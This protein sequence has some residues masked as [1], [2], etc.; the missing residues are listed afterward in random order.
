VSD[1]G[2]Q[3]RINRIFRGPNRK[4]LVVA[5]DHALILGPIPGTIDPSSQ[6]RRFADGGADAVLLNFGVLQRGID[7]L[8]VENAPALILRLDW[9][10]LWTAGN[11]NGKLISQLIATPEQALQHGADAVLT[12]LFVGT[13]DSEFESREIARNAQIARECENLGVPLIIESLARGK[14]VKDPLSLEW[15][16]LHTRIASEIG[17]DLIKTEY[18]GSPESMREIVEISPAPILVL[19]GARSASDNDALNVVRGAVE[20]GAAGVFFGRNVFQAANM[21][22]FLR[23]ARAILDTQAF[24]KQ[25]QANAVK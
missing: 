18:T 20:A 17:A 10:S 4:A 23:Q 24:A 12:Y 16:K 3:I 6:I 15:M 8:L 14:E 9:T 21:P 2:K 13:G 7:S 11:G 25:A 22:E 5:F 19:G 1:C